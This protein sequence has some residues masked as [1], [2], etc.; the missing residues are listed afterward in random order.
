[1]K[2][3]AQ[4]RLPLQAPRPAYRSLKVG[5]C[6]QAAPQ[7]RLMPARVFEPYLPALARWPRRSGR[8][9]RLPKR[10]TNEVL[11]L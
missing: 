1:M 9:P 4:R 5:R 11:R 8:F 10:S 7:G 3:N 6:F 2:S